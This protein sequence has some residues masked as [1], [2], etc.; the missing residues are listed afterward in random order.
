MSVLGT[1]AGD[2]S[3]LFFHWLLE[4]APPTSIGRSLVLLPPSHRCGT[5]EAYAL[6]Q[7]ESP[8]GRIRKRQESGF[9][10]A[11]V[12][13]PQHGNINPFPFRRELVKLRLRTG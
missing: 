8:A 10:V 13:L 11:A 4:S 5:P 3:R 7:G 2:P 6:R 1:D 9:S 12:V